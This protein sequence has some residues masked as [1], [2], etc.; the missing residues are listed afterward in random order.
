M[1]HFELSRREFIRQSG[2]LGAAS[3]LAFPLAAQASQTTRPALPFRVVC[4]GGHPDD[5]ES[6]CAGTL[7]RY[8]ESGHRVTIL[9][10]TR[11]ER[12][13]AGK[14]NEEAA[15]IR[16]AE[17]EAA[18]KIIGAQA[19]FA[20]QIDGSADF[21]RT[22]VDEMQKLLATQNPDVVFT[23]WPMDSHMD[24]QVASLCAIRASAALKSR[25][26]VYLFEV[27]T[28][29]QTFGFSPN[30]YIDITGTLEKKKG[31]LFAHKSQNGQGIWKNHHE[32]IASWRGRE[33]GVKAAEA[34]FRVNRDQAIAGLPGL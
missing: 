17:C 29:S 22:R 13:I 18:C 15:D 3:M 4:V 26:Q 12:G 19:A 6:G 2:T 23:H 28:G 20:G 21:T 24:H 27:N 7:A 11:G 1:R 8:A 14:S 34:F 31:A 16:T 33:A 25:P 32:L 5:P 9:Y 30:T 10:L